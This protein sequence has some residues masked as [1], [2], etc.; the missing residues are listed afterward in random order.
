LTKPHNGKTDSPLISKNGTPR[1]N[2]MRTIC[3]KGISLPFHRWK[4]LVD[5]LYF[6][7]LVIFGIQGENRSSRRKII[8]HSLTQQRL[9]SYQKT[10]VTSDPIEHRPNQSKNQAKT[11]SIHQTEGHDFSV[12]SRPHRSDHMHQLGIFSCP[13]CNP[14]NF[15]KR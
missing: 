12:V 2:E 6:F 4:M 11:N 13:E 3:N 10:L 14:C 7:G 8:R 1:M 9:H 5:S 15:T